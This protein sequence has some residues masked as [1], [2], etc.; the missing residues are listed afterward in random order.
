MNDRPNDNTYLSGPEMLD[1]LRT[2]DP[3]AAARADEIRAARGA[4]GT[5]LFEAR[6]RAQ[7][8]AAELGAKA[9]VEPKV[10]VGIEHGTHDATR[11]ELELLGVALDI[12]FP[13]GK[14]SAA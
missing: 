4:V 7:L 13:I 2:M 8:D 1:H 5:A 12:D 6:Q 10:I 11:H 3:Q 14:S 9:G